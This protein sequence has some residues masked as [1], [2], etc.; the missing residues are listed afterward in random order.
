MIREDG[1]SICFP[2]KQK[3]AA[4]TRNHATCLLIRQTSDWFDLSETSSWMV[5]R[6]SVK[7]DNLPSSPWRLA[8]LPVTG[9]NGGRWNTISSVTRYLAA[10]RQPVAWQA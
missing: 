3:V 4:A 10:G 1:V 6:V 7:A 5:E 9:G 8:F 2:R